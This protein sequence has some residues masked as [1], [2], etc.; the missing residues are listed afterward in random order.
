MKLDPKRKE[1]TMKNTLTDQKSVTAKDGYST[2]QIKRSAECMGLPSSGP[3]WMS[4]WQNEVAKLE[5]RG[6]GSR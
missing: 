5:T 3:G 2:A 4:N 1:L 6:R